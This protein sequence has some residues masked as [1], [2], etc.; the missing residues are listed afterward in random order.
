MIGRV[1]ASEDVLQDVV[2]AL[3]VDVQ[4]SRIIL[5]GSRARGD[6]RPDSDY[7][8]VVELPIRAAEFPA[9]HARVA[10]AL[11]RARTNSVEVDFHL[12]APGDI[13]RRRDDPGYMEW[14]IARDGIVVYPP[15]YDSGRL[16]P[17]PIPGRARE[18]PWESIADWRARIDEDVGTLHILLASQLVPWGSACF[19]AQQAAEKYLKLLFVLRGERPMRTHGLEELVTR[20][21]ELGLDFPELDEECELLKGYA[22]NVRYPERMPIPEEAKGRE[23]VAAAQRIIEAA[24][25]FVE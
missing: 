19:H 5:F 14:D 8:I 11:R 2:R 9:V 24:E 13:E 18:E 20:L 22:V 17:A 23:I 4:P 3:A 1:A 10:S 12:R 21:R 15:R 7:D 6:A 16:R 25:R